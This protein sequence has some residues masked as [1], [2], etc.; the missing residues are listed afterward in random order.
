MSGQAH[1]RPDPLELL[2]QISSEGRRRAILRVYLGYAPGCGT[3]TAMIDEARRRSARGTDVVVAAYAVHDPPASALAKL[4]VIGGSRLLPA[5]R[6][7]DLEAVLARNPE[8]ACIDDLAGRDTAGRPR[9]E[10]VPR[11]LAAGITVLATLHVLSIRSAA[12]AVAEIL[13]EPPTGPLL[14]DEVQ[15]LIDELELEDVPPEELLHRIREHSILTPAQLAVAMQRELRPAVLNMLRETALRMTAD[16]TDRQLGAYLPTAQSPLEFRGR[17]VLSIEVRK[18]LDERI[19]A[20]ARYAATQEAK[21]SVVTVRTRTMSDEEKQLMGAYATL[22]HQLKGEFVRLDG[23][24]VAATLARYIRE[25]QATEVVLGHR[26]R[27]RWRPMD[28]T[29][30]LIRRLAGVDVH[31]LRAREA[32]ASAPSTI[33]SRNEIQ[34]DGVKQLQKSMEARQ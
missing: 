14:D 32:G 6:P 16:H 11:M 31:I 27:T 15:D 3:T 13:G 9:I 19:R 2:R 21:F 34:P 25:S 18:G 20:V 8:V 26:R 7:L 22:A 30:E 28:T 1:D 24:N 29:S 5:D 17:I 4:E 23:S 12:N 10:S 33:S